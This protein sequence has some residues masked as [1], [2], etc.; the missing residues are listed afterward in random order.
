MSR[1][2]KFR[3]ISTNNKE[4]VYGSLLSWPDGDAFI[5]SPDNEGNLDKIWIDEKTIGQ[6]T[7]L[8]DKN[9]TDIYDG[10][11]MQHV[12][13]KNVTIKKVIYD[14]QH[15]AFI[16]K[17]NNYYQELRATY[18]DENMYADTYIVIGNIYQNPELLK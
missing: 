14:N 10:D 9:G 5:C 4:W 15:G 13:D 2:I 7:G 6:L 8:K 12:T 18:G 17:C 16:M 11:I 1:E 3:G